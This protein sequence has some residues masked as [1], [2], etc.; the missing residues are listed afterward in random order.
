[1]SGVDAAPCASAVIVSCTL[2]AALFVVGAWR[3]GWPL[4]QIE[5]R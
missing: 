4:V 2:F 1:M 5:G 3:P